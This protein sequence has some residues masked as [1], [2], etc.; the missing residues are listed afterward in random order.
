MGIHIQF[1]MLNNLIFSLC[2]LFERIK[3]IVKY[4][5]RIIYTRLG[6]VGST[7][8]LCGLQGGMGGLS[9][10]YVGLQGGV[11]VTPKLDYVICEWP[12]TW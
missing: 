12:L 6:V 2:I 1:I 4:R 10:D 9:K 8:R 3:C 11:Q 7:K 5:S